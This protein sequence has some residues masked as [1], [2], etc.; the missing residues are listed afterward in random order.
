MLN[1]TKCAAI[2]VLVLSTY[3]THSQYVVEGK[4]L[5]Q[6]QAPIPFASVLL[7]HQIDSNMAKGQV[8]DGEGSFKIDINEA[9]NYFVSI[10]AIGYLKAETDVQLLTL[11]S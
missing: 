10:S 9:G 3:S 4:F 2:L 7:L 8:S 1:E 6:E 11:F 5:D